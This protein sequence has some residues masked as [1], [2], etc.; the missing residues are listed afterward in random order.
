MIQ[1]SQT[2]VEIDISA[3]GEYKIR[4]FIEEAIVTPEVTSQRADEGCYTNLAP[5]II[6]VALISLALIYS[7]VFILYDKPTK[8]HSGAVKIHTEHTE[9][10]ER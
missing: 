4:E 8:N 10:D 2:E 7:G 6:M 5:V 9:Q 3:L 1:N